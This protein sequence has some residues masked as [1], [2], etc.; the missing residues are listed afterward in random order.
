MCFKPKSMQKLH[1]PDFY[2][3][4]VKLKLVHSVQYLGV[5]IRDDL[6]DKDDMSRHIEYIYSKGNYI[7]R[8]FYSCS[9]EVKK[10]LFRTFC[11]CMYGGHLWSRF[12]QAE[13]NRVRVAYNNV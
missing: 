12:T 4:D 1:V 9:I 10:I 5:P 13:H 8:N 11:S 7:I 6:S 2:L 3:N